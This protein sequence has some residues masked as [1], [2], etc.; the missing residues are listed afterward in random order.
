MED[1]FYDKNKKQ[2][3]IELYDRNYFNI[4]KQ[5]DKK[6]LTL[7]YFCVKMNIINKR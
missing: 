4:E 1:E 5:L 6:Y 7:V 3:K 2:T